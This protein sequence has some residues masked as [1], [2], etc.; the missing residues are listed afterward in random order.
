[1]RCHGPACRFCVQCVVWEVLRVGPDLNVKLRRSH[2]DKVMI[3]FFSGD[4]I[5]EVRFHQQ[6]G[7]F[8]CISINFILKFVDC[9]SVPNA[10][11]ATPVGTNFLDW[12]ASVL[13][14]WLWPNGFLFITQYGQGGSCV[15]V[16]FTSIWPD[17]CRS[18]NFKQLRR[19]LYD[20]AVCCIFN[21]S[22]HWSASLIIW[23]VCLASDSS[24]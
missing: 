23:D 2:F 4:H 11:P 5:D 21:S 12:N 13:K 17:K 9:E 19:S 16:R 1:M 10:F 18:E 24:L 3:R 15:W 20:S 6:T 8:P 7:Y 22:Y 14:Y